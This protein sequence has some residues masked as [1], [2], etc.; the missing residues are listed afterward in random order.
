MQTGCGQPHENQFNGGA[1]VAFGNGA[2]GGAYPPHDLRGQGG[3][4]RD[5]YQLPNE[6]A[7]Q[8]KYSHQLDEE[9]D[10]T[11]DGRKPPVVERFKRW[12]SERF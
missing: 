9:A 1:Q 11:A 3:G 12:F 5:S 7:A 6:G 10:A 2:S 4:N 8:A